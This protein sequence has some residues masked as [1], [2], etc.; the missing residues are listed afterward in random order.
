MDAYISID[1][2]RREQ[3]GEKS[4]KKSNSKTKTHSISL[5]FIFIIGLIFCFSEIIS[6][7]LYRAED[8]V[9]T[10]FWSKF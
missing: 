5:S 8:H 6:S 7:C 10:F 2:F 1:F 3:A 4:K 9:K